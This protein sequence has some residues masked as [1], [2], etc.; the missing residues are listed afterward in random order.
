VA[1]AARNIK[2]DG[3]FRGYL[4]VGELVLRGRDIYADARPDINTWPPLF[5]VLCVPFALLARVSVYLARGVW[6]LVNAGLVVAMLRITTALVYRRPLALDGA[7]GVSIASLAV[8]GPLVLTSRFFLGNF[9]R[10]QINLF[11]LFC[12]LA[13]CLLLARGRAFGGGALLGFAAAVKVLPVFF[14]P[15]LLAKRWWGA[16]VAAGATGWSPRRHRSWS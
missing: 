6:L 8:L 4:E 7:R 10:L 12:C 3:D 2:E 16:F 11:I 5:A 1:S 15:Y 14:V 9:D 13:G